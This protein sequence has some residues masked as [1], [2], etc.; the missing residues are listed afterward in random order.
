MQWGFA[1]TGGVCDSLS[2]HHPSIRQVMMLEEDALQEEGRGANHSS[3][4]PS[5]LC[6]HPKPFLSISPVPRNIRT[7]SCIYH[8][9]YIH[10]QH[11]CIGTNSNQLKYH[12]TSTKV[13]AMDCSALHS[14]TRQCPD[15]EVTVKWKWTI[16][17][18]LNFTNKTTSRHS[19]NNKS[20]PPNYALYSTP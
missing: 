1:L 14:N 12:I 15:A 20:T 7:I 5:P 3:A 10:Q 9:V 8:S 2:R 11:G 17:F 19:P 6:H 13:S 18:I 16:L 4:P